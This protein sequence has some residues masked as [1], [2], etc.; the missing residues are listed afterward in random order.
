MAYRSTLDASGYVSGIQKMISVTN[1]MSAGL[2][3]GLT[4]KGGDF[5]K[6]GLELGQQFTQGMQQ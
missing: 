4:S 3:K 6:A 2:T 1:D 5:R